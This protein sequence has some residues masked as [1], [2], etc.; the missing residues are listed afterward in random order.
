MTAGIQ[1]SNIHNFAISPHVRASFA[2]SF[3]PM[4][5]EG[6]GN[7]GRAMRPQPCVQNKKA[8][9][10]SHHRFT[11]ITR[12]SPRNGFTACFALSPVSPALLPPSPA[13]TTANLTPA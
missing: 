6:A 2:L 11:G 4:K 3:C 10:H 9:K 7:A 1:F 8:H 5:S 13:G 12:H